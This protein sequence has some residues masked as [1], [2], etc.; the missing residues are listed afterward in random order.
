MR[1]FN[2]VYWK[3]LIR[4]FDRDVHCILRFFNKRFRYQPDTW[5][6]FEDVVD[7]TQITLLS[8]VVASGF[9]A[10]EQSALDQVSWIV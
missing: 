2:Y 1:H 10:K 4:Y 7:K 9:G 8:E 3:F 6:L 5:P